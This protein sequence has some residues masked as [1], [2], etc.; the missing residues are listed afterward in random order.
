VALAGALLLLGCT[1]EPGEPGGPDGADGPDGPADSGSAA[2]SPVAERLERLRPVP[3]VRRPEATA[4]RLRFL[5][6]VTHAAGAAPAEVRRAAELE[7]LAS[8]TL[9]QAT[10]QQVNAVQRRLP[11]P[12]RQ[13]VAA[14]VEAARRLGELATPQPRL[15]RWRIVAPPAPQRLLAAYR[16]GERATGVGWE[17]LAAIHLVET[18]MGRIRGVSSAGAQG[19]MQFLPSTWEIYGGDGDIEDPED[20]ILAAGRL[21]RANGAARD[22]GDALWAYNQS[23]AYVFAVQA[24]ARVMRRD[25]AAYQR[26]RHW[27]VVYRHADGAVVLPEGYPEERAL[28]VVRS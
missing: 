9:A 11:G 28:P 1:S 25:P 19:P 4:R 10:A 13:R 21:L 5:D 23:S 8:R 27:R 16:A 6:S 20:A 12:L 7:Q 17:H 26:H 15:P 22:M 18:R 24:Y 14:D 3:D 2:T